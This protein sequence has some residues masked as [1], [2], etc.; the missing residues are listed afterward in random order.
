MSVFVRWT[1]IGYPQ[2]ERMHVGVTRRPSARHENTPDRLRYLLLGVVF[3]DG[4]ST[5]Q[6][7]AVGDMSF[8]QLHTIIAAVKQLLVQLI[9]SVGPPL[10]QLRDKIG[11]FVGIVGGRRAD[12]WFS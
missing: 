10:A 8:E 2:D 1:V 11:K 4:E 12:D 7:L 9:Q 3:V 5:F 6:N